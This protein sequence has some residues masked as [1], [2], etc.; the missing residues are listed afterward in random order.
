MYHIQ[1]ANGMLVSADDLDTAEKAALL[2][3]NGMVNEDVDIMSS[4]VIVQDCQS[5]YGVAAIYDCGMRV[6]W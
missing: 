5:P 3:S 4:V 1:S 2:I 6:D